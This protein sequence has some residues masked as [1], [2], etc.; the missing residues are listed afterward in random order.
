MQ[1]SALVALL[2]EWVVLVTTAAP[3]TLHSSQL[4]NKK[5]R[6]AIFLW[7]GALTISVAASLA[8][9]GVA[10]SAVVEFW[11]L[12]ETQS[13]SVEK[14]L[15]AYAISFTPWLLLAI[16]GVT[17]ALVNQ[18]L[19][20]LLDQRKALSESLD[21][22]PS[23][24]FDSTGFKLPKHLEIHKIALSAPLAFAASSSSSLGR[25]FRIVIS[26]GIEAIMGPAELEAIILHESAHIAQSHQRLKTFA[27]FLA[28]VTPGLIAS[29]LFESELSNLC[30]FAAD[31]SVVRRQGAESLSSAL[32]KIDATQPSPALKQRMRRLAQTSRLH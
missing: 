8:A 24:M 28:K 11:K 5:P 7:F 16:A 3:L 23:E 32:A 22:L 6:A 15:W 9:F 27:G 26:S 17:L 18:R 19:E 10:V 12:L 20:P 4:A 31:D 14:T 2:M 21:N 29:R 30:E 13:E 1:Q 25:R